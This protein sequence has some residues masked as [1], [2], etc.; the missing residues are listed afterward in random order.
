MTAATRTYPRP[1][2][3]STQWPRDCRGHRTSTTTRRLLRLVAVAERL[4]ERYDG[5]FLRHRETE[6]AQLGGVEVLRDLGCGP[7][8]R[9]QRLCFGI[10]PGTCLE[11][12]PRV[13]EVDD[14]VQGLEVAVVPVRF[15][16][17]GRGPQVHVAQRGHLELPEIRRG[18]RRVVAAGLEK[19]A[20]A[21]IGKTEPG[22]ILGVL[23][24]ADVVVG[25]VG[26]QRVLS[27]RHMAAG[28]L[29]LA[30]EQGPPLALRG[31]ES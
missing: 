5:L 18:G 3:P 19:T 30:R 14:S 24:N 4:E 1:R 25:V 10:V 8:V 28:A 20:Q 7:A 31:S 2:P 21:G 6:V 23:G 16:E 9:G 22:R 15:D 26:E 29:R 11:D 27:V 12:V 17:V 13:V